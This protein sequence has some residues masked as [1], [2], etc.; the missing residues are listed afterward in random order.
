MRNLKLP[1]IDQH[2]VNAV[3]CAVEAELGGRATKKGNKPDALLMGG[4]RLCPADERELALLASRT[5]W[6]ILYVAMDKTQPLETLTSGDLEFSFFSTD[7]VTQTCVLTHGRIWKRDRQS[8]AR[9][10][11]MNK[12]AAE[13]RIKASGAFALRELKAS[14]RNE[15]FRLARTSIEDRIG[16]VQTIA[17]V[18]GSIGHALIVYDIRTLQRMMAG[19]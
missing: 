1:N 8:Q 10:I 3:L 19:E 18:L 5:N 13:I 4:G 9:L 16:R 15:G 17:P 12:G 6:D 7:G 11:F 14:P 2:G